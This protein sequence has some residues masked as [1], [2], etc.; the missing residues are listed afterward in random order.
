[1]SPS[2]NN[3]LFVEYQKNPFPN[4]FAK[5]TDARTHNR[6]RRRRRERMGG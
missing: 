4:F 1:M 3:N 5:G 6:R 2:S